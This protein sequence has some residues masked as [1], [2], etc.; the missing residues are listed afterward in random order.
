MIYFAKPIFLFY[1]L[2]IPILII[3][4]LISLRM[5]RRKALRFANFDAIA[6]IRG[7]DLLSKNLAVLLVSILIVALLSLSLAG[8]QIARTIPA[9]D[10][11]F[12]IAIDSSR[13][14][15][16]NDFQ[17][18]RLEAAKE[19]AVK[20]VDISPPSTKFSVISFSGN[21]FIEETITYDKLLIKEALK[22]IQL[23]S[24][25]GTDLN[26]AV[27]TSANLLKAEDAKA[28]VLIGD[29]QIN[30]GSLEEAIEY[31][32]ENAVVIYTIGIGSSEG[33]ETS[34]GLSKI[35]EDSLSSLAFNTGGDYFNAQNSEEIQSAMNSILDLKVRR[36]LIDVSDYLLIVAIILI[37]L[38]FILTNTKFAEFP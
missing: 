12:V 3:A 34:Y 37:A 32:N 21:A 4:H 2:F 15:E 38:S 23:S 9:T 26:E 5:R 1:L 33:G 30:V 11:S 18:N 27:I 17:P 16:A 24:I 36:V 35:D 14:M 13:S 19:T 29:G 10:Y 25:G 8:M 20:F 28:I 6:K 22:N 31:A 7:I